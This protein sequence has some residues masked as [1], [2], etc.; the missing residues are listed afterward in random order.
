MG[1]VG[2][3]STLF[4]VRN[5]SPDEIPEQV[6]PGR[7]FQQDQICS[8]VPQVRVGRQ[9]LWGAGARAGNAGL[10]Q[11]E[12]EEGSIWS[13]TTGNLALRTHPSDHEEFPPDFL[14]PEAVGLALSRLGGGALAGVGAA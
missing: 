8:P 13:L 3:K 2:G 10:S 6:D 9:S 14:C 12:Q 11:E 7:L 4:S 5:V 1:W